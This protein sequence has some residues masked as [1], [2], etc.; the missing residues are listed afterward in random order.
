MAELSLTLRLSAPS[1][2]CTQPY[3]LATLHPARRTFAS[4]KAPDRPVGMQECWN[5]M[6]G[7]IDSTRQH[8]LNRLECDPKRKRGRT[9]STPINA[10]SLCL[11]N[12]PKKRKIE[13]AERARGGEDATCPACDGAC[14]SVA[15]RAL[16]VF[17]IV[18]THHLLHRVHV[19]NGRL[20]LREQAVPVVVAPISRGVAGSTLNVGKE[21]DVEARPV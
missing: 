13:V 10:F 21:R 12:Q 20:Q 17:E 9:G 5:V 1:A 15:V 6:G 19:N 11:V 4:P 7:V 14:A 18:M 2:S 3:N 8:K 16:V